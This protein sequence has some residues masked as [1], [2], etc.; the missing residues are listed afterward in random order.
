LRRPSTSADAPDASAEVDAAVVLAADVSRS[1]DDGEFALERRGYA[2]AIQS[3]KLLDAISTGHHG[4][5]ALAYVEWAGESEQMIVVD[6]AIIRKAADARAFAAASAARRVLSSDAPRSARRS[7]SP[8]H[9]P[10]LRRA[11]ALCDAPGLLASRG[12]PRPFLEDSA[13]ESRLLG[14]WFGVLVGDGA[15]PRQS[16]AKPAKQACPP[17]DHDERSQT[18]RAATRFWVLSR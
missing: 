6:W 10:A 8:S 7:I 15:A 5:I 18:M 4:A 9:S 13:S 17:S 14:R 1:I 3:Q 2:E 11:T 16:Q 12:D